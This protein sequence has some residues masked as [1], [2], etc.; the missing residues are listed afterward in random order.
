M[1]KD[2]EYDGRRASRFALEMGQEEIA[3]Y[4]GYE[5]NEQERK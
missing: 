4:L 3:E 5:E 1:N 2:M